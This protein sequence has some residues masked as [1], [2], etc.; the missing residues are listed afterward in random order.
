MDEEII[1]DEEDS[2]FKSI[3]GKIF[4]IKFQGC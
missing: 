3:T 2:Y 4:Y 1:M